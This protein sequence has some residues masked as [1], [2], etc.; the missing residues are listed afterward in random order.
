MSCTRM[1]LGFWWVSIGC[2]F[3]V[4]GGGGAKEDDLPKSDRT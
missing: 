2:G 4:L 3:R 1:G